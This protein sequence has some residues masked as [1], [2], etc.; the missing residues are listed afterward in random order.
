MSGVGRKG[1]K[2]GERRDQQRPRERKLERRNYKREREEERKREGG[3]SNGTR[4]ERAKKE[5]NRGK[6]SEF[7]CRM[8]QVP[9]L[10]SPPL[11]PTPGPSL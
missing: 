7:L 9:K 5:R 6:R 11:L 8:G 2:E 1:G 4:E 3:G 10:P